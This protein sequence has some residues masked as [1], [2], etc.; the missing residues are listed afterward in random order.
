MISTEK[1]GTPEE[2]LHFGVKGMKWGVRRSRE[3]HE[4]KRKFP[5][6][7]ARETEIYRARQSERATR[8]AYKS[9]PRGPERQKLKDVHLK[10]PDR[11]T[12]YRLTL[13]EKA[14]LAIAAGVALPTIPVGVGVG[15]RVGRRRAIEAQQRKK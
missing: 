8:R 4:F 10:N 7:T 9:V 14:I 13:G 1:P 11:A 5:T 2:L 6:P 12:A 3:T 15:I